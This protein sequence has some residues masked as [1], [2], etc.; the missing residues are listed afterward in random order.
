MECVHIPDENYDEV[1]VCTYTGWVFGLSTEPVNAKGLVAGPQEMAPQLK[2]KVQQMQ[3]ELEELESKVKEERERFQEMLQQDP[4][5]GKGK[6]AM[7][8]GTFF[9]VNDRFVLN[10]EL[11]CYTLSLELVIPIEYVFLQVSFT[12]NV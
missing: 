2:V 5:D 8:T 10:K 4:G 7:D 3:T 11:A 6:P 12:F 1:I 9:H